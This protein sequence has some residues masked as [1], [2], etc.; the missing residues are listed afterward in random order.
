MRY[1]QL[2]RWTL[3]ALLGWAGA[4]QADTFI[5]VPFV[6]VGVGQP[7]G[8][9]G[10][11]RVQAP[12]VDVQVP[13][14]PPAPVAVPAPPPGPVLPAPAAPQVPPPPPPPVPAPAPPVAPALVRPLTHQEFARS[15]QPTPGT[16][17]VV[18]LH[19]R[20]GAPVNVSFTLPAGTPRVRVRPRELEFD[21]GRTQV[22]IR[23][24]FDGR[25]RVLTNG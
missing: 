13:G 17:N 7:A 23:F 25:V 22:E 1:G 6:R 5:W 8:P 11:V 15:F 12:F 24:L 18:L 14:S 10:G 21:Y 19:P 2:W 9:A 16:H 3:A 20:T 4:G